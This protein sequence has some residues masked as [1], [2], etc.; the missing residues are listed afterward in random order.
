M[1]SIRPTTMMKL[2]MMS[3]GSDMEALAVKLLKPKGLPP[4][5]PNWLTSM[6]SW[7]RKSP[8]RMNPPWLPSRRKRLPWKP[9]W[10]I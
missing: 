2:H 9:R 7:P 6:P 8:P 10:L 4:V 3:K 1:S 5:T